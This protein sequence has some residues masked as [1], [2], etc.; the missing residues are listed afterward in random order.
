MD[1]PLSLGERRILINQR[2]LMLALRC[3]I[4]DIKATPAIAIQTLRED[5]DETLKLLQRTSARRT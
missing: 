3:L 5:A 2:A 1:D 4:G